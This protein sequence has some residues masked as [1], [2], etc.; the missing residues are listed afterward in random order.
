MRL[1]IFREFKSLGDVAGKLIG[2]CFCAASCGILTW[3]TCDNISIVWKVSVKPPLSFPIPLMFFLWLAVYAMF[4][5]IVY[6]NAV[7]G[8]KEC[9]RNC[10]DAI[11]AYF[12][13]LFWCP[14]IFFSGTGL[15]ALLS[16]LMSL[17]YTIIILMKCRRLSSILFLLCLLT[18]IVEIYFCY[19]TIGYIILN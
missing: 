2:A 1:K 11:A 14:L 10:F 18:A 8:S 4:G 5:A 16:I 15:I 17:A 13:S 19:F 7:Y 3:V 9:V 12:L 6:I